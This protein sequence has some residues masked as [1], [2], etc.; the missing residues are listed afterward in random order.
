MT[1]CLRTDFLFSIHRNTYANS[2]KPNFQP[3]DLKYEIFENENIQK[4]LPKQ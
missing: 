3:R 1:D 2:N 4:H